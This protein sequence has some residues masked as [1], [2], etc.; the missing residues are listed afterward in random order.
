MAGVRSDDGPN[1]ALADPP[2]ASSGLQR[3]GCDYWDAY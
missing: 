1:I 2:T 3:A